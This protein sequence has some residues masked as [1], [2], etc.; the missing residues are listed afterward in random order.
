MKFSEYGAKVLDLRELEG[1]R[2]IVSER[3][4]FTLHIA[5]A[6]FF[7]ME[8]EEIRGKHIRDWLREMQAKP[9][10]DTRGKRLL[11]TQTTA[12]SK[13]LVSAILSR[14]VEDELVET[15]RCRDV[16]L[17]KRADELLVRE[18][19]TFLTLPEQQ[20][21]ATC[22][23][24][25]YEHRIAIRFAI[26]TG[27]RQ[28][29]QMNLHIKDVHVKGSNPHVLVRFGSKGKPPKN[30]KQ[31]KVPLFG[32]GLA[33]A[34]EALAWVKDRPNPD[35]LLFPA[36]CGGRRGVGKPLGRVQTAGGR[37]IDAWK[38]ARADVGMMRRLRWHDLRHTCASNLVSGVLGRR[39]T[40]EEIQPLMGHSSILITQRYAHLGEDALQAAARATDGGVELIED[41]PATLRDFCVPEGCDVNAA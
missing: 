6:G 26:G 15:N 25:P 8:L 29:E 24:I 7:D 28:G 18:S 27:L 12:R 30:G 11:S 21:F 16:K 13:A 22:D 2:G 36:P 38:A 37:S 19:C 17:R 40:L 35:G 33:A 5:K 32:D 31:R 4:R 14:A 34:R 1:I 9:A 23:Q 39:W 20:A 41:V 10:N 3:N